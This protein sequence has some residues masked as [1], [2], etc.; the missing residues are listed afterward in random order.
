MCGGASYSN[1]R[2][3][4]L[5]VIVTCSHEVT[6]SAS[7]LEA[8][9]THRPALTTARQ[10]LN[11]L[12]EFEKQANLE[13]V[14]EASAAVIGDKDDTGVLRVDIDKAAIQLAR[15]V[16]FWPPRFPLWLFP[17]H[18]GQPWSLLVASNSR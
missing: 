11:G 6:A 16:S 10:F 15:E 7:S 18:T 12:Q 17:E 4:L 5:I 2:Y 3:T 8:R 13:A 1:L 14:A 9:L